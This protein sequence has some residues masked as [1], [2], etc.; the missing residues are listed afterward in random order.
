MTMAVAGFLD[1]SGQALL[2]M[3]EQAPRSLK[4]IA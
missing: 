3:R 4:A 2:R 1:A